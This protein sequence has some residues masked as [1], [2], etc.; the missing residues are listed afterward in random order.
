MKKNIETLAAFLAITLLLSCGKELST[1]FGDGNDGGVIGA[2]CRIS[3]IAYN[4]SASGVGLGSISAL[5]NGTDKATAITLFDSLSLSL[6]DQYNPKYF[7]DTITID[8]D[9]YF[10]IDNATKR[11]QLLH[12]LIDPSLPNSQ[13]FEIGYTYDAS[14]Y[15]TDKL[16]SLVPL[17]LP[18]LQVNYT[19]TGGNLTSMLS[20]DL[21]SADVITDAAVT[22]YNNIAPKNYLYIFPDEDGYAPFNQFYNFGKRPV[23][24]VKDLKV[25]YYNSG[26]VSDS[27]VSSFINYTMSRDNYVVGVNMVGDDQP[28]IPAMEGK[29]NF[30]YKCK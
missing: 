30:S 15:L 7:G 20:K 1:E 25:R 26:I 10:I 9:Q 28:S 23:N 29:L 16:Y 4:D 21:F 13:K 5:I 2:D 14:G 11:I 12:G 8:P 17:N 24:A 18:F 3:K 6:I 22:Y 19:Y 27:S